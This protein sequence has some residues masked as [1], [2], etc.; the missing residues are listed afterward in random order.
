MASRAATLDEVAACH[1]PSYVARIRSL[2]CA[3]ETLLLD[4]DTLLTRT[5]YE[6]A[7]LA[8]GAAIEAVELGG[9]ALVRPPGHH[10]LPDRAM[11]F[12]VFGNAAIAARF[13]QRELGLARVAVL[14][15]D[16]HHGNGTQTIFWDDPS[17][18]YVSLHQWP[19]YPG[20]GGPG[21][22]NETTLNVPLPAG[23]G[24]REYVEAMKRIVEPAIASFEPDLLV[25]SAGFDA[26]AGD[27]LADMRLTKEGFRSLAERA[28]GLCERVALVLE[29]GYDV[30]ALPQLVAATL[31]GL[32]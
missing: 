10:A 30:D 5:T 17:V 27:P 4:P 24:D 2:S 32:S 21:D 6:A 26:A 25:V 9:F 15:W 1:D 22:G 16:V 23:C 12:C 19:L 13:A 7:L 20:S 3:G 14:D 8:A 28:G 31:A 18:L 11:G 29:G